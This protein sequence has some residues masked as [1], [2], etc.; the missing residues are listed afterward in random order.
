M[1]PIDPA[2][3]KILKDRGIKIAILYTSYLPLKD[4]SFY[5]DWI[6]PF[7]NDI[8]RHMEACASPGYYFEVSLDQGISDAMNALFHK[9]VSTPRITS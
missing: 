6:W 7:Q 4:N 8:P 5:M 3:C 2:K 1:E 9:I